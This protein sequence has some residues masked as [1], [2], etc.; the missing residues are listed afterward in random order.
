MN[1][2]LLLAIWHAAV[3]APLLAPVEAPEQSSIHTRLREGTWAYAAPRTILGEG[4]STAVTF[5]RVE[6]DVSPAER[7]PVE[8]W[9]ISFRTTYHLGTRRPIDPRTRQPKPDEITIRGPYLITLEPETGSLRYQVSESRW[10]RKTFEFTDESVLVMPAIVEVQ[11]GAFVYI[12]NRESWSVTCD[13]DFRE[14]PVGPCRISHVHARRGFYSY[15]ETPRDLDPTDGKTSRVLRLFERVVDGGYLIERALLIWDDWGAPRDAR[16]QR[17][18][19]M[20]HPSP[21]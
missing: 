5:R 17:R 4:Y 15:E 14:V 1:I 20:W 12:D 8:Q 18:I 6:P 2:I 3:L 10:E 21:R 7:E 9:T 19:R 11:P 13:H 16:R